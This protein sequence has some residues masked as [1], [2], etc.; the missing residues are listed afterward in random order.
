MRRLFSSA[1]ASVVI[2]LVMAA[3]PAAV[4]AQQATAVAEDFTEEKIG[5]AP[6]SFSTPIGWWSIGTNGVDTKPV[7]F[8]DGTRYSAQAATNSLAAQAQAQA[9]GLNVHQLADTST[10]FSYF[11]IALLNKT[12]NFTQGTIVTR[13]AIVGGDLDTDAGLVFNYQPNGDF[14]ALREDMDENSLIL[15]SV[16][17]GQ[18]SNLSIIDNVPGSLAR[19]HDLQLTVPPG[20]THVTGSFDG[21]RVM[22]VDLDAPISGQVGAIAKTDT[23]A[24]FNTFTVDPNGQ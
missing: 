21:Q 9:Q 20:G 19:W 17:Q 4:S 11:P 5:A 3:L 12:T 23:V 24:V 6:T 14:L 18:Q 1:T 16:S 13:F 8:E 7:L 2:A 10:A 15:F 22:D